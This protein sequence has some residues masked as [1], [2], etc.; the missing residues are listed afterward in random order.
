MNNTQNQIPLEDVLNTVRQEVS[1]PNHAALLRWSEQYPQYRDELAE[2]FATWAFQLELP[3][4]A[5]V[6]EAQ[7]ANRLVSH[8]LGILHKQ[9]QASAK[10]PAV[11]SASSRLIALA[12]R[13]GVTVRELACRTRLDE[14]IIVKFDL[15]RVQN[16][17]RLCIFWLRTAIGST[18]SLFGQ[19]VTGPPV[20]SYAVRHKSA[21]RPEPKTEDFVESVRNSSL[22]EEDKQFWYDVAA[23]DQSI[24]DAE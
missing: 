4:D 12:K 22:S 15:R 24:G 1:E 21:Q 20:M 5:D 17:P 6:D 19:M 8:A 7:L 10:A 2:F 16:V 9:R 14:D 23:A 3:E 18:D 13:H 11:Q